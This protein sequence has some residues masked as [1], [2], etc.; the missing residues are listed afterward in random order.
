MEHA[1]TF[2]T[3]LKI[4]QRL[5]L[6]FASLTVL[7]VALALFSITRLA[8]ITEDLRLIGEDRLPKIAHV[9]VVENSANL[10]ARELRNMLISDSPELH[11]AALAA[12]AKARSDSD[13]AARKLDA[14]ENSPEGKTLLAAAESKRAAFRAAQDQILDK[15]K[16]GEREMAQLVLFERLRP[17]QLAYM[18]SLQALQD[19]QL[20]LV[21]KAVETGKADYENAKAVLLGLAVLLAVLAAGLG[22]SITRSV[23]RPL[24]E[25]VVLASAVAEGDLTREIDATGRDEVAQ[26]LRSLKTMNENLRRIVGQV[27]TGSESIATGSAQI[28]GGNSDLSARTEQQAANLQ[29]TAATMEEI[30][31]TARNNA[32]T[33]REATALALQAR[34]AAS[35][36]GS[37][38]G[39]VVSAM[40]EIAGRSKKIAEIIGTIDA[41]AFQTNILALNAAVEAAR[42]GEQGRG[43]AVVAS[44]VRALAQR[45][46]GAAAEIKTLISDSV[47]RVEVGT[48][49]VGNAGNTM[50][51]IVEQVNRVST[52]IQEIASASTEQTSGFGQVSQAVS[53]LDTV[54]QQNAALVEESAAAASLQQQA[55]RLVHAV[56]A[57]RLRAA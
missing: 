1:V 15:L 10:I 22:W 19:F 24:G 25:A 44:E 54:T 7:A 53:Q 45:S 55:D 27:R 30:N 40:G 34:D 13:A 37:A 2:L 33:A 51:E 29:Q 46:A 5:A 16:A 17:T 39:E 18:K 57:F 14:T 9:G 47:E 4:G 20:A 26:L 38:V 6:A 36:G 50:Q 11:T 52:L 32:E 48:Q 28:A 23:T 12:V 41:I 56:G 3:Q 8:V 35:R 21:D 49:L 31:A 42:A 43:F